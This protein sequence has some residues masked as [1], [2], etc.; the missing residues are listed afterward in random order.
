[1]LKFLWS[2]VRCEF[3]RRP[4]PQG[5]EEAWRRDPLAHPAL[6]AMSERELADLPLGASFIR[7]ADQPP[8][9]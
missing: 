3:V 2:L 5:G 6:Q 4:Q 7:V 1:M 9:R 8:R